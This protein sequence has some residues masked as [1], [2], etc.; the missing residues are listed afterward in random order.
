MGAV[1]TVTTRA[2]AAD[3]ARMARARVR[4]DG[5]AELAAETS[6]PRPVRLLRE[7]AGRLAADPGLDVYYGPRTDGVTYLTAFPAGQSR[8]I[9]W[10]GDPKRG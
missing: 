1:I 6:R 8:P 10:S 5:V 7:V 3:Y 4:R 9:W 2:Q